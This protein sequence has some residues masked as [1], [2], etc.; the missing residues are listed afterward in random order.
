[1]ISSL[2]DQKDSPPI[3]F[4]IAEF[5]GEKIP[6]SEILKAFSIPD[7]LTL[8]FVTYSADK[9]RQFQHRGFV[10]NDQLAACET[11]WL[12]YSDSDMV[13]HPDYFRKLAEELTENHPT[14]P[15]MLTAGR[16]SNQKEQANALVDAY[17]YPEYIEGSWDQANSL[18]LHGKSNIGAGFFQLINV[19]H[20]PHGGLYVDPNRNRDKAMMD[21]GS[22]TK[23]DM[24]FRRRIGEK[25]KL[26]HWFSRHQ[27]HLNHM[28]DPDV[29]R[30]IKELR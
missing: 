27:I 1:M 13:Y 8:K 20:A 18:D 30:N 24:Q 7:H 25:R 23:S 12:L 3:T 16:Q 11:P 9:K 5:E 21:K 14:A 19:E 26:P 15:Y 6:S 17:E 22:N 2:V 10:R 28:R 4:T 29:G